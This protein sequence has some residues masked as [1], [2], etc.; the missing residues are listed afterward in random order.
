[1]VREYIDV[2]GP[3]GKGFTITSNKKVLLVGG[4]VGN[5]PLLYL[6]KKLRDEN[7]TIDYN[8]KDIKKI[9]NQIREDEV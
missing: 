3:L 6:A 8:L 2:L 7:N 5:A 9:Q 4:G 1:M